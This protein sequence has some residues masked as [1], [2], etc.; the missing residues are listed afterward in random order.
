M[1]STGFTFILLL[2]AAAACG[3]A[4]WHIKGGS[5][6]SVLG[7]PPTP[8][9]RH[10][11]SRYDPDKKNPDDPNR[12]GGFVPAFTPDE[13]KHIRISQNGV[14]ASFELGEKGWQAT[15]PWKD[16]MDPRAAVAIV[17]FTLG[18][19]VEDVAD[20]DDVD[21][22]KAGLGDTGVDIRL[23]GAD[24]KPLA[25]YK[26]GRT[27]PWLATVD[28][29]EQPIP[30][31][32]VL[33]RDENHKS[34]VYTCTGD[35]TGIFKDGLKQL[36]D[37]HPFYFNPLNVRTIRIKAKE[38]ELTLARET[39][40]TEWRITMPDNLPTDRK[41]MISLLEGLYELRAFK[42]SDR[43]SVTLP[44]TTAPAP[45][46]SWHIGITSFGSDIETLLEIYPPEAE[47]SESRE[48]R[49]TVS[50]RPDTIFDLPL[51][52][53]ANRVSLASLPL[54]INDLRNPRLTN[55]N[56]ESRLLLRRITVQP[57]TGP[58]I[59]LTTSGPPQPWRVT[60]DGQT[61][62][63]NEGRLY[64]LMKMATEDRATGF[65]SDTATDFTPWGLDKPLTKVRF[66]TENEAE[67]IQLAFGTDGKGGYFVNRVG[68]PTVMR[69]DEAVVQGIPRRPYEWRSSRVWSLDRTSLRAIARKTGNEAPLMLLYDFKSEDWTANSDRTDL[70]PLLIPARANFLLGAL[71]GLR[72]TRWLSPDDESAN[73]ALA[74]PSLIFKV[75]EDE[76][77]EETGDPTGKRVI[78]DLLLAPGSAAEKPAFYYGRLLGDSQPFLLDRVTYEKLATVLIEKE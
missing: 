73:K 39:P 55:I 60:I 58:E 50:D 57:S 5:F 78:R 9:G 61:Q 35:I 26:L 45:G 67:T 15:A 41:A 16:R 66:A 24:H 27:T 7:A 46:K 53:E 75:F 72:A 31:V 64:I 59:L 36:R 32:F 43:A 30:T 23:E 17:N 22:Q 42:V 3:L 14:I 2:L 18:M 4:G 19:R 51:K 10:I 11:Y 40:K 29:I 71:E 48:V 65:V 6:D 8:V 25:R 34:H 63:A 70:T 44:A 47:T 33:P 20:R 1:R 76:V 38:G 28:D 12:K 13:V 21:A 62:E 49:A 68:T 56:E 37:H 54:A 74:T 69:V 77:D 52:P